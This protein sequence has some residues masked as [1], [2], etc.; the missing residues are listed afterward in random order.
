MRDFWS[1]VEGLQKRKGINTKALSEMINVDYAV[2]RQQKYRE[3]SPKA[4]IIVEIASCLHTTTDY[5]LTGLT[6]SLHTDEARYVD[7]HAEAQT[8]IRAIMRDPALLRALYVVIES[9]EKRL[10]V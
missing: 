6:P 1:R 10:S 9:T 5:L 7:E 2:I 8:L 3:Q 4:E